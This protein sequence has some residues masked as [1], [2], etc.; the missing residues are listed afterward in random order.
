M[1]LNRQLSYMKV[2]SFGG[3]KAPLKRLN[4]KY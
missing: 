1:Q 3:A 4:D 2:K